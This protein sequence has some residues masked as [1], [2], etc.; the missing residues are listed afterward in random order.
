MKRLHSKGIARGKGKKKKKLKVLAS[1]HDDFVPESLEEMKK[2]I[3]KK[4]RL[5]DDYV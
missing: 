5:E 4:K 1:G 3:K 2:H